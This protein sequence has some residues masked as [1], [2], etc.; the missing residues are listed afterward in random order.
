MHLGRYFE[1][2]RM[3][4]RSNTAFMA[5]KTIEVSDT[6]EDIPTSEPTV[7]ESDLIAILD[8]GCNK[9]CH[10][11]LWLRNMLQQLGAH[12]P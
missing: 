11:E 4:E 9:T 12:E 8:S 7:S 6:E 1:D 3:A 5:T 10:G 2:R